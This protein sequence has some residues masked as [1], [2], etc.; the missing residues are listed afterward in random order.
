MY[1]DRGRRPGAPDDKPRQLGA[2]DPHPRARTRAQT[3]PG[4]TGGFQEW[5]TEPLAALLRSRTLVA[6]SA[7]RAHLQCALATRHPAREGPT[8]QAA[9]RRWA[10]SAA[11]VPGFVEWPRSL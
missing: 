8:E 1:R 11:A 10:A 7:P 3:T 2:S 6:L 5:Q 9:P 4:R